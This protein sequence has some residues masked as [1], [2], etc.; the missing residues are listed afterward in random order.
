MTAQPKRIR[1]G[2]AR[3]RLLAAADELFSSKGIAGTP[4]D[5]AVR[6]AGVATMTLYH[7]FDGKDALVAAYLRDRHER[8]M[9]RWESHIG[10]AS[11][12]ADRLLAIFDALDE[13]AKEGGAARG[14]AFVDA[15]AELSDRAHPAWREIDAH[16]R[17][18]RDRLAE[19]AES[20]DRA[21][22]G[23]VADQ[24]LLIYEGALSAL[25]IGHVERPTAQ[26]RAMAQALLHAS[27]D[28]QARRRL[29]R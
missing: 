13:W 10:A 28:S 9:Q 23:G 25:L 20:I 22:P 3:A 29:T 18:L 12:P 15:A 4:V 5:E 1:A 16:K 21:D 17:D 2:S 27:G 8:W 7:H 11:D 6:R 14:C 24:L 19:L 26:A